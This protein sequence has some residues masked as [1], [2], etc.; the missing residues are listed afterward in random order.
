MTRRFEKCFER[1]WPSDF[2]NT[3]EASM[4]VGAYVY[5]S[6]SSLRNAPFFTRTMYRVAETDVSALSVHR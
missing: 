6:G 5:E 2:R 4:A 3:S 1:V